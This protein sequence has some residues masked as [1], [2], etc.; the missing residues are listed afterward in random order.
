MN[1]EPTQVRL[2]QSGWMAGPGALI[3]E[4]GA[5]FDKRLRMAIRE[6]FNKL[7]VAVMGRTHETCHVVLRQF[8]A[9]VRDVV[10]W[11]APS[12]L[13]ELAGPQAVELSAPI[14]G[15]QVPSPG[16]GATPAESK[17][18]PMP[19]QL[20]QESQILD[21][22]RELGISL[23][24]LPVVKNGKRGAGADIRELLRKRHGI[25]QWSDSKFEKAWKRVRT[26]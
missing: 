3:T 15:P 16:D 11:E 5:E 19:T 6:M 23:D 26:N 21:A 13:V 7:D 1:I 10:Q 4:E 2:S 8:A 9:W 18:R 22:M 20:W 14:S 12:E 25:A 17:G 24:S